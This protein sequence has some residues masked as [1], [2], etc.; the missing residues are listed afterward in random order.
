MPTFENDVA[1]RATAQAYEDHDIPI[2]DRINDNDLTY[3][4]KL[5]TRSQS[6]CPPPPPSSPES[7]DRSRS[8]SVRAHSPRGR[9][10]PS[11]RHDHIASH[12][13]P[14]SMD[15]LGNM[16]MP[17]FTQL[18]PSNNDC[19]SIVHAYQQSSFSD[20]DDATRVDVSSP[21]RSVFSDSDTIHGEPNKHS[22][23]LTPTWD[24]VE[25]YKEQEP[26][27]PTPLSLFPKPSPYDANTRREYQPLHDTSQPPLRNI[28]YPIMSTSTVTSITNPMFPDAS[29]VRTNS[30]PSS[31]T[32]ETNRAGSVPPPFEEKSGWFPDEKDEKDEKNG[33]RRRIGKG[34]SRFRRT[35]SCGSQNLR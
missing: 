7:R 28:S 17:I 13:S 31:N 25:Q 8:R 21:T 4:W 5:E 29:A 27:P 11:I 6:P 15:H 18:P 1:S 23:Y 24:T 3:N 10:P 33:C 22:P 34:I 16:P 20:D 19:S 35:F 30:W 9:K 2:L 32:F 26:S 12:K 14:V